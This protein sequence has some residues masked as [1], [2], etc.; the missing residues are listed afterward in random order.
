MTS[1]AREGF[2]ISPSPQT[3]EQYQNSHSMNNCRQLMHCLAADSPGYCR[4]RRNSESSSAAVACSGELAT[5]SM[6]GASCDESSS[7]SVR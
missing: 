3:D 5:G 1:A 7:V 6:H 4:G 2:W